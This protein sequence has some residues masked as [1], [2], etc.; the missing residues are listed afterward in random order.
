MDFVSPIVIRLHR[1][2][3]QPRS[4]PHPLSY[5]AFL[6]QNLARALFLLYLFR[7]FI[8]DRRC[9]I[10][11]SFI[12]LHYGRQLRPSEFIHSIFILVW[13]ALVLSWYDFSPPGV[14]HTQHHSYNQKKRIPL[15]VFDRPHR[16]IDDHQNLRRAYPIHSSL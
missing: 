6:P 7:S 10:S 9:P 14:I 16:L 5:K 15:S 4:L 12:S 1:H 13:P 8:R 3:M 2:P 11:L